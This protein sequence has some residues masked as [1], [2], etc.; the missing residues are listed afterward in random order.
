MTA[1]LGMRIRNCVL[2]QGLTRRIRAAIK[3][4]RFPE[5]VRAYVAGLY[6]KQDVPQ[7]VVDALQFAG[8]SLEGVATLQPAHDF[9]D[10]VPNITP[11]PVL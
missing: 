2:L 11:L 6:P 10:K 1:A 3:E 4:Q 7:W 9:Y 5:F 8:I